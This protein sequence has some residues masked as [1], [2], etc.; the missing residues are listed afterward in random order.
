M[1]FFNSVGCSQMMV[2]SGS[3]C[4]GLGDEAMVRASDLGGNRAE[5]YTAHG[6]C[7]L[8]AAQSLVQGSFVS[9]ESDLTDLQG[10]GGGIGEVAGGVPQVEILKATGSQQGRE[11]RW[12]EVKHNEHFQKCG[13]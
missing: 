6:P 12:G 2:C 9:S 11:T 3:L 1:E 13:A 10:V 8:F 5:L 7:T 4:Q